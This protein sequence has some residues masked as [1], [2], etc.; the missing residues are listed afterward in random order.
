MRYNHNH[1]PKNGQFCSGSG[2]GSNSGLTS[3]EKNGRIGERSDKPVTPVTDK[4]IERVPL[5]KIYGLTDEECAVIQNEH[6]ELLK[7]SRDNNSSGEAAFVLNADLKRIDV[8]EGS[9]KEIEFGGRLRGS[10]L[11]VLHNHP[12]NSSYSDTDIAFLLSADGVK[13]LTIIKNN[14]SVETLTKTDRFVKDKALAKFRRTYKDT[15]KMGT[16]TEKDKAVAKFLKYEGS[17]LEW[18]RFTF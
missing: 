14:G 2:G 5:A 8:F 1:D 7:Y 9:D 15:V 11:I 13:T 16:D 6:R 18:N 12:R 10:N 4:A 3:G 17:G